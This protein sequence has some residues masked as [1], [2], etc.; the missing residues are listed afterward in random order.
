MVRCFISLLLRSC[1]LLFLGSFV[2]HAAPAP[3][4]QQIEAFK[5]LS[6]AEQKQLA[7]QFG[8]ELPTVTAV[9]SSKPVEV[10]DVVTPREVKSN[11][12]PVSSDMVDESE[13]TLKPFGYELFAGNPTTFAPATDIPVPVDYIVGPGDEVL[14]QLYGKENASYSLVV[15]REGV[16]QF[17]EVG[18]LNVAGQTYQEMKAYLLNTVSKQMIGVKSSIT[19]GSLRSIRVFV[20]GEAFRPG[21]YTI[22]ALSTIT[23]ALFVSGGIT[24]LGSLRNIQL[25]RQGTVVGELD[26]YDLLLKGD[27]SR[28]KRLLPGDVIFIPVIDK[29]VGIQGSVRR[30]ALYELK[31]EA[32]LDKLVTLAGGYSA[33]AYPKLTRV[34]SVDSKGDRIVSHVDLNTWSGK[35]HPLKNG[36]VATVNSVLDKVENV[37]WIKGHHQRPGVYAWKQGLTVRDLVSG[38][39]QLLPNPDLNYALV[40]REKQPSRD[41]EVIAFSP[42]DVIGNKSSASNVL[43]S[44]R[45]QVLFFGLTGNQRQEILA[46]VITKLEV[47]AS[48]SDPLKT[49][50]IAGNVRYPGSYPL[51]PNMTVG[52]LVDAAGGYTES[53]YNLEAEITRA[54]LRENKFQETQRIEVNLAA[55][56]SVPLISRDQLYVKKVPNWS[57][58]ESVSIKGEVNFPGVYPI[59][60]GDS[61]SDLVER[62]GGFTEYADPMAAIFLRESLR[63]REEQQLKKY[64]EQLEKDVAQLK[65]EAAQTDKSIGETEALG[66]VLLG[67]ISSAQATG[68]LVI[69]LPSIV[70]NK[71]TDI[72]LRNNDVL[73]VPKAASEVSVVGEVQ[74]PTS[75]LYSKGKTVF[76]YVDVSGGFTAKSD[77][78]RVYVIKPNG[79]IVSV[80]N[81]WF[82]DK[83]TSVGPGDTVV[84][85]YDSYAVSPMAYWSSV[86]QIV[87]QLATTVAVLN[88]VGAF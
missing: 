14:V 40:V 15:S 22:S 47:Q 13:P 65:L 12:A 62:A 48:P 52:M 69:D 34:E 3:T 60:K 43:L 53:A 38:I 20:L 25:K 39:H 85:P 55:N 10:P 46:D 24:E 50:S 61:I 57:E 6:S 37:V 82:V 67:Q 66:D 58:Y 70:G 30:S 2:A 35:H 72:A 32:T 29:Q 64:R 76:D 18:P 68:R 86:S 77:D 4:P 1:F 80:K 9:G 5:N 19:M 71:T 78:D 75:H 21:S 7:Q 81:G 83:N 36:D 31:D 11:P 42:N 26:L 28:D 45:D 44:N 84:V 41:I 23:N 17:P 73:I 56:T 59:F 74:F 27:T 54:I 87:F 33:D 8:V 88:T 49:V 79:K 16:I 63:L 51:T